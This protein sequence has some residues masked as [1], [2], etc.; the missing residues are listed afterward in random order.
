MKPRDWIEAVA[1][2]GPDR[3]RFNSGDYSGP[4]K[5]QADSGS[6]DAART[7]QAVR[8]LK[9]A[10]TQFDRDPQQALR[11]MREQ[12]ERLKALAVKGGEAR[13]AVAVAGL[14]IALAGAPTRDTLAQPVGEVVKL[15]EAEAP[16]KAAPAAAVA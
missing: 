2:V 3:R 15:F 8:I 9:S 16:G 14:E 4:L 6:G 5:R 11:A 12:A 10:L 13:L 1:Y 7:D